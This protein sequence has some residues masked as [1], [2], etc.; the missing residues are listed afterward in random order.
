[1]NKTKKLTQGA[2]LLAI[3]GALILIDRMTAYWF[4][5]FVVLVAPVIIIVY[6]TM[7][8]FKD[9]LVLSIGVLIIGFLLGNFQMLYVIYVPVGIITGLVYAYGVIK[10]KDKTTL[11]F[12]SCATYI[13]GE[14]LAAYIFY[15]MFGIPVSQ[16]ITEF[17]TS[18]SEAGKTTGFDYA[19]IF[20][21]MKLDFDKVLVI[22]FFIS[23]ALTGATEGFLIHILSV[24]LL[25]RFK[26]KDIGSINIWDIKPNKVIA[27]IAFLSTFFFYFGNKITNENLYY[28]LFTIS[29]LGC[30]VLLYYGYLFI[31]LYGAIVLRKNIAII[32]ILLALFIPFLLIA[33][34]IIGFLYGSG[35]LRNYLEEKVNQIKHE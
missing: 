26:I 4:S 2:M 23:N 32:F 11:L 7:Q 19:Q 25:K 33:L 15:P 1:M 27:Y 28:T 34:L 12:M 29:I 3:F 8:S 21:S 20:A 16:F 31:C 14:L 13:A 17:K 9:G 10:N 35:P 5:E 6:S 24:F 18:L 30:V 22:M